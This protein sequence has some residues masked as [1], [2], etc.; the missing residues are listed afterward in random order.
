[1]LRPQAGNSLLWKLQQPSRSLF[2]AAHSVGRD[3]LSTFLCRSDVGACRSVNFDWKK[4]LDLYPSGPGTSVSAAAAAESAAA[5]AAA[6]AVAAA[7]A[8]ACDGSGCSAFMP[9]FAAV[10][11][12]F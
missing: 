3:S 9:A 12:E 4:L 2:P 10:T 8:A 1:M 5:A 7:A 11:L 6:V